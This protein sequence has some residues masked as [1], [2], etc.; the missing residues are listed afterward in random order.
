MEPWC[1]SPPH[2]F[3]KTSA[4]GRR[5]VFVISGADGEQCTSALLLLPRYSLIDV[6]RGSFY[7]AWQQL[8]SNG[9]HVHSR[10]ETCNFTCNNESRGRCDVHS[11]RNDGGTYWSCLVSGTALSIR[12]LSLSTWL[13]LFLAYGS[14]PGRTTVAP[15][16]RSWSKSC[17]RTLPGHTHTHT[18]PITVH[19]SWMETPFQC[20][21]VSFIHLWFNWDGK[22]Q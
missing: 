13:N 10:M 3:N 22:L 18:Q 4:A 19:R 12:S 17:Q 11:R 8:I 2:P 7:P 20:C 16:Y 15:T 1:V 14:W 6:N 9:R 5:C 21:L